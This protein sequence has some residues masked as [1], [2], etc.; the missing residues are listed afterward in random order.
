MYLKAYK[1]LTF[2]CKFN[3]CSLSNTCFIGIILYVK[4][5]EKMLVL[6]LPVMHFLANK[7]NISY[8]KASVKGQ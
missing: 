2:M 1:L 8:S 4:A 7:E 3:L 5:E 6:K